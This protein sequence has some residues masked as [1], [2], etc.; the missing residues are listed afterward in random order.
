MNEKQTK[1]RAIVS[2]ALF[3]FVMLSLTFWSILAPRRSFSENENRALQQLPALNAQSLFSRDENRFTAQYE[4][5]VADQFALRDGWITVKNETERLLGKR[6]LNGVYLAQNGYLIAKETALSESK[7]SQNLG[8]VFDFFAALQTENPD[9]RCRLALAPNSGEILS[10][11][12]PPFAQNPDAAA[13]YATARGL[14]GDEF[15]SLSEV[16]ESHQ[17]ESIYY[18]SDH[19]W[20]TLGAYYAYTEIAKSLDL[21]PHALDDYEQTAVTDDFLGTYHSKVN[22][23][24]AGEEILRFTLRENAPAIT[25]TDG[26]AVTGSLYAQDALSG[27]DKYNYFLGGNKPLLT[28]TTG[29]NTGRSLLLVKDSYA[30]CLVPFLTS[31]FDKIVCVDLRYYR[32]S[33]RQLVTENALTDILVLYETENFAQDASVFQ[34]AIQP[35]A[36]KS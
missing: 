17:D 8:F 33:A 26:N 3:S 13:L 20:T 11:Y 21:I 15:V 32:G 16:L 34:L 22:L 18:R 7:F 2:V 1:I 6:D 19:H 9:T 24:M 10:K 12:L 23:P 31:H 5:Y 25:L 29:A 36:R 4:R 28:I 35:T 27:K 14:L 30:H